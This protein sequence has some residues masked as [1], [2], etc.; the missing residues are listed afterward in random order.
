MS[1]SRPI[2]LLAAA[3]AVPLAALVVA[4]CGGGS[5]GNS[6]AIPPK[7]V[8]GRAA[9]IGLANYGKLG[10][11]LVDRSGHTLYLFEKDAAGKSSCAAACATNWPPLR[12]A[13]KPI[14]GE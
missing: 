3:A 12:A 1:R 2:T 8:S 9:T 10:K 14:A 4:G 13:V 6:A 11:V 5:N 7:T